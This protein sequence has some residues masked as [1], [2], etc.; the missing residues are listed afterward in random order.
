MSTGAFEISLLTSAR[1]NGESRL[2]SFVNILD[3]SKIPTATPPQGKLPPGSKRYVAACALQP[4]P[5]NMPAAIATPPAS[6]HHLAAFVVVTG[7]IPG[8]PRTSFITSKSFSSTKKSLPSA[9]DATFR[10]PAHTSRTTIPDLSN[11]WAVRAE[12]CRQG[13]WGCRTSPTK[14]P[15]EQDAAGLLRHAAVILT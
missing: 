1:C 10:I 3:S 6:S 14:I 11:I 12:P 8:P 2:R 4:H 9:Y 7:T 15:R 13:T 5:K